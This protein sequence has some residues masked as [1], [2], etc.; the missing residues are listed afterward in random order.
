MKT[1]TQTHIENQYTSKGE[2]AA[3]SARTFVGSRSCRR[4]PAQ[5][6][7]ELSALEIKELKRAF[8]ALIIGG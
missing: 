4:A 2:S 7:G 8:A 6:K 5:F 3:A 1:A